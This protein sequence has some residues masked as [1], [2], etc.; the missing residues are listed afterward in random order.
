MSEATTQ[1]QSAETSIRVTIGESVLYGRL[2]NTSTAESLIAQLPL[3]L[4]FRDFNR[5]EKIATVPQPL[6]LEG[7][8]AGSDPLPGEIGYYSPS[9]NLVLYYGDVGYFNGIVRIGQFE[10]DY[11]TFLTQA[12]TYTATIELAE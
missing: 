5:L 1:P 3:T 8:P 11:V 4:A 10:G 7:A 6:S 2:W 9:N 12:D